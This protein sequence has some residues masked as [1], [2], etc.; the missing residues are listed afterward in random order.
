[1]QS[2]YGRRQTIVRKKIR[3]WEKG[4]Q[5]RIGEKGRQIRIGGKGRQKT[6]GIAGVSRGTGTTFCMMMMAYYARQIM[7]GKTAV[8]EKNTTRHLA[9]LCREEEVFSIRGIDILRD[10][11]AVPLEH[12][13][14]S[15]LFFDYG[16]RISHRQ[17]VFPQF[18]DCNIRL[19]TAS[20]NLWKQEELFDFV[21]A[22]EELQGN[23]EWIYLIPFAAANAVRKVQD[24]LCRRIYAVA[25]EQEWWRMGKENLT[26]WNEI[27]Q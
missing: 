21:K 2:D 15:Y 4:R 3:A 19:V 27:L 10:Q 18:S 17:G 6:I 7:K 16:T 25:P 9:S 26:L 23:E 24:Q 13:E 20:L 5:I 14:Y 11:K 12:L 1:M 22:W 8:V